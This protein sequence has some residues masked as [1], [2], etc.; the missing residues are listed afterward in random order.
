MTSTQTPAP[1]PRPALWA[2]RAARNAR[3]GGADSRPRRSRA[4]LTRMVG[5]TLEA[6]GCQASVGDHCDVIDRRRLP[7]RSRSRR[8]L[9]RPSVSDAHR[10][11]ARPRAECARHSRASAPAPCAVGPQLLGRIIDGAAQPLDGL[12]PLECETRVRLTGKPINPL[13]R[14]THRGAARRRRPR[15][16]TRC[17]PSAAASASAC[18][19]AAASARA[20]CSA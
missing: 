11:H 12:G 10:R 15:P 4:S 7:R 8:L 3:A 9:R 2:Q 6:V 17:S 13:A 20:C 19:P 18:S 5:L 14:A 16:S 1:Q